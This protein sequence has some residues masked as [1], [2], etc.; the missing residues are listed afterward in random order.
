MRDILSTLELWADE[1]RSFAVATVTQTWGSSPRP[2]G[3]S[4]GIC[5]DGEICGSVSGGCV[6]SAVIEA[7]AQA[8]ASGQSKEMRFEAATEDSIWDVGLSCGGSIQVWIEPAPNLNSPAEWGDIL[9]RI[10]ADQPFVRIFSYET[11]SSEY[12]VPGNPDRLD[13]MVQTALSTRSSKEVEFEGKRLF[14]HVFGTQERLIII[15]A[16]HIAVPLVSF[17]KQLGFKTIVIDPRTSFT[18]L[19]RF[20]VQ[21]DEMHT[22]WPDLGLAVT[23]INSETYVVVL[24]HDPKIDDVALR[25]VLGSPVAYIGALGSR[26]TQAKRRET[27]MKDGF[28]DA[29]LSRIYGPI[30]LKIG[31][32]S[33]EEIALSIIAEI[34]QVRR[35]RNLVV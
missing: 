3:A 6:E 15:G 17:A 8:L 21:P 32:K 10:K 35:S 28:T 5:A 4:M 23:G 30:G 20:P 18:S 19:A 22:V 11:Q 29:D 13:G 25:I 34:I 7:A 16:V 31:A 33:P 1:G 14:L 9:A 12:W 26:G 27:L 24:T 2:I